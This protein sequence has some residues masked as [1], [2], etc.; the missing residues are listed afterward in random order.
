[1]STKWDIIVFTQSS[2]QDFFC[3]YGGCTQ[4]E[5]NFGVLQF[6]DSQGIVHRTNA[7]WEL[8]RKV[9]PAAVAPLAEVE[10]ER[11]S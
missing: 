2:D 11:Q 1:M 3:F 6:L 10:G 4:V 7:P 8:R 5:H 9:E